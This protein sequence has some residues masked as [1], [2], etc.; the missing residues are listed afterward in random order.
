MPDARVFSNHLLIDA[1]A[2]VYER[3]DPAYRPLRKALVCTGLTDSHQAV[4][5]TVQRQTVFNS[6]IA[7]QRENLASAPECKP[8]RPIIFTEATGTGPYSQSWAQEYLELAR[9]LHVPFISIRLVCEAKENIARLT[10]RADAAAGTTKLLDHEIARF[11]MANEVTYEF[12]EAA[13]EEI[14]LDVTRVSPQEAAR[15]LVDK[16]AKHLPTA[17]RA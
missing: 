14:T 3:D 15:V 12:G 2:V 11:W 5:D 9:A 4:A 16:I 10:G 6:L 13:D 1:A 17:A 7:S 8:F